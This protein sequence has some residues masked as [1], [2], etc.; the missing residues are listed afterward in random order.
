MTILVWNMAVEKWAWH[1]IGSLELT[2]RGWAW[3]GLLKPQS[4]VTHLLQQG[5]AA[6]HSPNGFTD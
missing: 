6:N 5:P 3:H 2:Q 4:L 1:G